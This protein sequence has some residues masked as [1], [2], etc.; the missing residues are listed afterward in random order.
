MYTRQTTLHG[1]PVLQNNLGRKSE[2]SSFLGKGITERRRMRETTGPN[3]VEL[4]ART[5]EL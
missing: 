4:N 3:P 5:I 1:N 2:L